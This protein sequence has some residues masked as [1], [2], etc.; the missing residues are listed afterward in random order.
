M[1]A[2]ISTVGSFSASMM[3]RG[4]GMAWGVA[5]AV[6]SRRDP[7]PRPERIDAGVRRREDAARFGGRS[8]RF[9][10]VDVSLDEAG[11]VTAVSHLPRAFDL[12]GRTS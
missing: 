7:P 8:C 12:D 6:P 1:N 4:A 2:T 5:E 11:A 10:V 9:D 3:P